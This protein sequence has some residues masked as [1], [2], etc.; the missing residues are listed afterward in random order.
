MTEKS[1]GHVAIGCFFGVVVLLCV[2]DLVN[3][4]FGWH[5]KA[6]ELIWKTRSIP[7][8]DPFSYLAEGKRWVDSHWL[9]QMLVFGV[10]GAAGYP[11]LVFL[12]IA[13][14]TATFALM[15]S[16]V[17]RREYLP[18]SLLVGLLALFTSYPRFVIRP[19]L[20]TL[21]FLAAFVY[22]TVRI[23]ERPLFYLVAIPLSQILWNN[24]H[25]LHV[26]G[27]A[28]LGLYLFGDA[29]Q[30]LAARF[31]PSGISAAGITA[32]ELRLRGGL[33]GLCLLAMMFNANGVDGIS[34]PYLIFGELRGQTGIFR[35]LGELESPF[36]N[37]SAGSAQPVA[38]Y[39]VLLIVSVL[40]LLLRARQV[41]F[42]HLLPLIAFGYLSTLAFRNMPLFAVVA[43]PLT[44]HN[45]HG[46]LDFLLERRG[47]AGGTPRR[48]SVATAASMVVLAAGLSIGIVSDRLYVWFHSYRSFGIEEADRLPPDLVG[49]LGRIG[50]NFFNT[51]DLG[52][53]LIW[54][55]YPAKQVA[56]D[57]RWEIYGSSL[58][59]LLA[60]FRDP[61][62]FAELA[63]KHGVTVVVLGRTVWSRAMEPWL[64]K[65][66]E[67]K[68]ILQTSQVVVFERRDPW[69]VPGW[70]A[71]RKSR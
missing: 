12:R 65:S 9:F 20:L 10:H 3:L 2:F 42:A 5:M 58:P 25:G 17:Y 14:V 32:R 15:L 56:L 16:T 39:K 13:V 4:D 24:I 68:R 44:I 30:L 46:S 27:V 31:L 34:Y 41:R 7:T 35:T 67:W 43:V 66:P 53:Y 36:S 29:L 18:V 6:G 48:L 33:M 63:E 54:K 8:H 69:G 38:A 11:G 21:L 55:L 52:G 1:L 28:F 70:P 50:G 57:G 26:L 71:P 40:A 64:Q 47:R 19:E 45:L 62:V 60:A 37:V 59:G 51:P 23:S 49:Y 22:A 61:A